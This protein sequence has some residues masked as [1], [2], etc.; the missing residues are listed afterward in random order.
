MFLRYANCVQPP[1]M[2]Y[3]MMKH[4]CVVCAMWHVMQLYRHVAPIER[5]SAY[6]TLLTR[7]VRRHSCVFTIQCH[8]I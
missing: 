2:R 8:N 3:V 1:N 5:N 7:I 6:T 4:V